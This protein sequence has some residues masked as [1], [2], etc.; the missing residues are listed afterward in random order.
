[1]SDFYE[2]AK[3]QPVLTFFLACMVYYTAKWII[4]TPFRM[5]NRWCRSRNIVS[6]GWPP[7]HLDADGDF[8]PDPKS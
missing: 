6:R 7:A 2:F 3:A 4:T 5:L 8:K 1:M